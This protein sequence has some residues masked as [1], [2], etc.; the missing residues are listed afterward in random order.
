MGASGILGLEG[1]V[2]TVLSGALFL[3]YCLFSLRWDCGQVL[4]LSQYPAEFTK[5]CLLIR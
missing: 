3:D 1:L 2:L 4:N 5:Y